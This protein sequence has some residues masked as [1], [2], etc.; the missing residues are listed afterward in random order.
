M[1]IGSIENHRGREGGALVYPVYSRRSGGLSLGV[2]LF[3][4]AKVCTFDC[5]YCEVFPFKTDISF[6]VDP[7]AA[8]L[9]GVIAEARARREAVRDICFSGNGEPTISPHFPAALLAAAK[10]RDELVPDA[11]LVVITNGTGLLNAQTFELLRHAATG[12]ALKLWLKLDAGTEDWYAKMDRSAVLFDRLIAA[13]KA[14][15]AIAPF[16]IQTM[17]CAINGAPPPAEEAAAWERLLRELAAPG[18]LTGVQIYGKARPSPGLDASPVP[19]AVLET[20]A[21]SLRAVLPESIPVEVF[22]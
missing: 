10:I 2:N 4:D 22:P 14:F 11:A 5:P 17:L 6:S 3:P 9:R 16:T 1:N 15:A 21:A 20:R 19:A 12:L 18:H 13:I 7:M 8:A